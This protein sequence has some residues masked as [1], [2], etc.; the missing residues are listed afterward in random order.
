MGAPRWPPRPPP[1]R[2]ARVEQVARCPVLPCPRA[3]PVPSG[4]TARRGAEALPRPAP[5][6]SV[7]PARRAEK[8]LA[9]PAPGA[10]PLAA[11]RRAPPW[12]LWRA[13]ARRALPWE[14]WRAAARG[15]LPW[16]LW[17]A[18]AWARRRAIA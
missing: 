6:L 15:A 14:L 10:L 16:E 11:A 9:P 4:P 7:P 3:A 2:G 1:A 12:E 18:A 8:P 13:A 5:M 17:R